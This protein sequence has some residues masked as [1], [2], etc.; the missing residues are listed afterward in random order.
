M[1]E[2]ITGSGSE[3]RLSAL[4]THLADM[5]KPVRPPQEL[6]HRL[7]MRIRMPQHSEIIVRLKDWQRLILVLGGVFSGA[8]VVLTV[9]RAIFHLVGRRNLG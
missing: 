7:R 4:E 5:L 8:L 3:K 6:L 1:D 2:K 9:A